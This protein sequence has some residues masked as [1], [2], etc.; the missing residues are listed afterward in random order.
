[1]RG[2]L[3]AVEIAVIGESCFDERI[4]EHGIVDPRLHLLY[5]VLRVD[6]TDVLVPGGR[7]RHFRPGAR[8]L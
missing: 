2:K 1:M 5:L 3:D 4:A 7:E 6:G 8:R